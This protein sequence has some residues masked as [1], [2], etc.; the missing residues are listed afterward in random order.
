[1]LL[2]AAEAIDLEYS[3]ST[4]EYERDLSKVTLNAFAKRRH[5]R[6]ELRII[7]RRCPSIINQEAKSSRSFLEQPKEG[8]I[9]GHKLVQL[10]NFSSAAPQE[11]KLPL[12]IFSQM[13]ELT[14]KER[15][16]PW[17]RERGVLVREPPI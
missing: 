13:P 8:L 15:T 1:M 5:R 9:V 3:R 14:R 17:P 16:G 6:F 11:D 2:E 10:L 12:R 4:V 7:S